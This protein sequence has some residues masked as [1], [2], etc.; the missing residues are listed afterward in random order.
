MLMEKK[1]YLSCKVKTSQTAIKPFTSAQAV[2]NHECTL[3]DN[4]E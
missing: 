1:M 4:Y 2:P 3:A